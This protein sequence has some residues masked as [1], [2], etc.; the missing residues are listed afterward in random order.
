[1]GLAA[2]VD[3]IIGTIANV[4]EAYI[5]EAHLITTNDAGL[6]YPLNMVGYGGNTTDKVY[7]YY[8]KGEIK[9][10]SNGGW[11][12]SAWKVVVVVKYTKT[13]D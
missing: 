10:R 5:E 7:A 4:D 6:S 13:T 9:V 2:N 1:M 8:Q 3:N 12:S 11:S